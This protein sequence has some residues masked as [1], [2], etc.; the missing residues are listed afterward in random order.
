MIV[1]SLMMSRL[2]TPGI[3]SFLVLSIA[4]V[5]SVAC[6]GGQAPGAGQGGS[7]PLN[8]TLAS[9]PTPSGTPGNFSS[10]LQPLGKSVPL[11]TL[12][13]PQPGSTA[14]SG[15]VSFSKDLLPIIKQQCGVCHVDQSLGG[16]SLK[17]YNSLI[18]GGQRG[19]PVVKGNPDGSLLIRKLRGDTAV[20]ERMPQGSASLPD[21]TIKLFA[22]WIAQGAAN[23]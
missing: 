4:L 16:F 13:Q 7:A 17:D 12:A 22:D 23:N 10:T 15:P 20:G 21:S 11:N 3:V 6:G 18:K 2:H 8:S 19:S 1:F 14:T 9:R 5:F